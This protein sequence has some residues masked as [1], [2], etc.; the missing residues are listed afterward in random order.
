[1]YLHFKLSAQTVSSTFT[2]VSYF[3]LSRGST[4][5]CWLWI[6]IF[7]GLG[8]L[9]LQVQ[10]PPEGRPSPAPW[11]TCEYKNVLYSVLFW[12]FVVHASQAVARQERYPISLLKR[13]FWCLQRNDHQR[14]FWQSVLSKAVLKK[15]WFL[16]IPF[17]V[18]LVVRLWFCVKRIRE[19]VHSIQEI[20]LFAPC[21]VMYIFTTFWCVLKVIVPDISV[22]THSRHYVVFRVI[23]DIPIVKYVIL[24]QFQTLV[25]HWLFVSFVHVWTYESILVF[26]SFLFFF[27]VTSHLFLG[28]KWSE[29]LGYQS[30]LGA[31][32]LSVAGVCG[33]SLNCEPDRTFFLRK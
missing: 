15:G 16:C 31:V 18:F 14:N 10:L 9:N 12:R 5:T 29:G 23:V 1:M 33:I 21:A 3:I 20:S 24:S 27:H 2:N 22:Q 19:L 6:R 25:V 8:H 4:R 30:I 32:C 11:M 26:D 28:I 17:A 13:Q 7:S